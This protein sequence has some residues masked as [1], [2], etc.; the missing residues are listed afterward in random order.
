M[1]D[2]FLLSTDSSHDTRHH[3]ES[4]HTTV[5][6]IA[7]IVAHLLVAEHQRS[8]IDTHRHTGT[9]LLKRAHH[10]AQSRIEVSRFLEVTVGCLRGQTTVIFE[11]L[12]RILL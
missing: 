7:R 8:V 10:V 11:T 2:L 6:R 3:A 4:K 5:E 9:L 1:A 12:V